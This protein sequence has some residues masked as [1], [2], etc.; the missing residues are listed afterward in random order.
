MMINILE[1]MEYKDT[2][3]IPV[4]AFR[5]NISA[6]MDLLEKTGVSIVITNRGKELFELKPLV[7]P[8]PGYVKFDDALRS[9]IQ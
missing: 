3:R 2:P 6:I 8:V 7:K 1:L 4:T 5:N 9:I